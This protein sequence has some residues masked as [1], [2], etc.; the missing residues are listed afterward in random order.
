[1]PKATIKTF[2]EKCR[3]GE[4]L[5]VLTAYDYSLARAVDDAGVDAVLVGDSL[6]MVMLGENDTLGVTLDQMI[7]HTRAVSRGLSNALLIADLPFMTYQEGP[8]QALR[9]AGALLQ[10]GKAQAVKLEWCENAPAI[11]RKLTANGIPVMGHLGFTPQSV[12]ALGGARVQGKDRLSAG[13]LLKRAR[14]LEKA[15][16]FSVVLELV[17]PALAR[18]ITQTLRIPT[19][20]IGAGLNCD[21]QVLVLHDMLGLYPDFT[22]KHTRVYLHLQDA[23]RGAVRQYVSDVRRGLFPP[24]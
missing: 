22:P 4:K 14:E 15:G 23:V 24:A 10:K 13:S 3:V 18:K 20:G 2:Q 8:L 1:M 9:S 11:V 7:H 21:G 19:I 17:P 5:A 12:H 6:G 16:A